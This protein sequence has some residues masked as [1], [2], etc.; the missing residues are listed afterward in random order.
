MSFD[1]AYRDTSVSEGGYSFDPKD[2]GGETISGIARTRFPNWEGWE[3]IDKLPK[4]ST[5]TI[6]AIPGMKDLI[7]D[8]YYKEFWLASKCDKV[9]EIA[10]EIAEELYEASVNCGKGNGAK[11]LQRA[12]NFL[13]KNGTVY[14]DLTIDGGVGNMT[15]EAL[16]LCCENSQRRKVLLKAQNGEQ[17][18]YYTSLDKVEY[19]WGWLAR[20]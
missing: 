5:D 11:F 15:L 14:K 20:C 6:L 8:F 13:N 3:Q 18:K 4:K 12:L 2:P 19:F 9:D 17:Y 1:K 16:K 7:K 10:P